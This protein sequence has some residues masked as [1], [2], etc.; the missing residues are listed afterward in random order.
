M[1]SI[2]R[3]CLRSG[4]RGYLGHLLKAWDDDLRPAGRTRIQKL[5]G[6]S[7]SLMDFPVPDR[8]IEGIAPYWVLD[9][10]VFQWALL[11]FTPTLD[12]L[13][14]FSSLKLD[15]PCAR[16]T[17]GDMRHCFLTELGLKVASFEFAVDERYIISFSYLVDRFGVGSGFRSHRSEFH[18]EWTVTQWREAQVTA[19]MA[20]IVS[21]LYMRVG[22][23]RMDIGLVHLVMEL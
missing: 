2:E 5:I 22:L 1:L 13:A 17:S 6:H 8:F 7:I 19:L 9:R 3:V 16:V 18:N 4:P 14:R 23:A 20:C 11:E 15:L 21:A 12:E 10:N